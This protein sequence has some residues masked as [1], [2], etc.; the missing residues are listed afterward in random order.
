MLLIV[1]LL[2]TRKWQGSNS[3]YKSRGEYDY[4][5]ETGIYRT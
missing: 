2:H 5:H 1:Y 4:V 3:E